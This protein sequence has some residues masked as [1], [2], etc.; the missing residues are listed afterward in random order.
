[1][2]RMP[3][4]AI[5]SR[6]TE[7]IIAPSPFGIAYATIDM[8]AGVRGEW[9]VDLS[10]DDD[11]LRAVQRIRGLAWDSDGSLM[12]AA[13]D[14]L[15]RFAP[16]GRESWRWSPGRAFGFTVACPQAVTVVD[17]RLVVVSDDGTM[18]LL[19]EDGRS[20]VQKKDDFAPRWIAQ[21]DGIPIGTDGLTITRWNSKNLHMIAEVRLSEK[22]MGFAA[23]GGYVATRGLRKVEVYEAD[24]LAK[25]AEF[26]IGG[27]LPILALHS[28]RQEIALADVR[29]ARIVDFE[30]HEREERPLD[31]PVTAL[32]YLG[33]AL[34]T[35]CDG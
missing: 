30:G 23:N 5:A 26:A 8:R 28:T 14:K 6:A 35:S 2:L 3:A 9:E 29:S 18:A 15:R 32:A 4:P 34:L 27:G 17:E 22:A 24:S 20:L 12:V 25:V 10:E 13:A 16:D 7:N 33:D 11:R 19:D 31:G 21:K 1:M